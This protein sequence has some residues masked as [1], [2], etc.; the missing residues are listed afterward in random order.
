MMEW[1][2]RVALDTPVFR[3]MPSSFNRG[4]LTKQINV[5]NRFRRGLTSP[6]VEVPLIDDR[7]VERV[8][9]SM[10]TDTRMYNGLIINAITHVIPDLENYHYLRKTLIDDINASKC[11]KLFDLPD[12]VRDPYGAGKG[13]LAAL[14]CTHIRAY[15]R[16][17]HVQINREKV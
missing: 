17:L 13:E 9:A 3:Q 2:N 1:A 10:C 11:M 12:A 16:D 8:F 6:D 14:F 15:F 4:T 7:Y 5:T